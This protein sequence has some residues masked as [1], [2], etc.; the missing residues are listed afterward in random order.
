[1]LLDEPAA[2]MN[3][4]ESEELAEFILKIRSRY[5]LTILLIEHHMDMVMGISDK[6]YVVD[7]GKLLASGTPEEIQQNQAVIDAYLGGAEDG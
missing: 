7:F 4:Q 6:I 3:P 1:M 2:G 5:E